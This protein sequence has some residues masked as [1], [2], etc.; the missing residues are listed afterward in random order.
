MKK[1]ILI[2]GTII[3]LYASKYIDLK[4]SKI[5]IQD[6]KT[7][8][9]F[10]NLAYKLAEEQEFKNINMG[11]T[12]SYIMRNKRH[13]TNYTRLKIDG[14]GEIGYRTARGGTDNSELINHKDYN[15]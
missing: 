9:E 2:A 15:Y 3:N 13:K 10:D 1:I 6:L 12:I 4:P 11:K 5:T 8:K 14:L 7:V